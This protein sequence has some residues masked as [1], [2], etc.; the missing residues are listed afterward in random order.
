M[1]WLWLT[2]GVPNVT[3]V[4]K[5]VQLRSRDQWIATWRSSLATKSLCNNYRMFKLDYGL[6]SYI[7]KL[8][9]T[10][11]ILLLTDLRTLT[12]KLLVNVGR[13]HGISK[14]DRIC[15]KCD[16]GVVGD[17]CMFSLTVPIV[18]L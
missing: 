16:A 4:K 15:S 13:Y 3:W 14:E 9:K 2:Q 11:R 18:T 10:S 5:A 6:E 8:Q 1:S 12:N 17:E 7:V